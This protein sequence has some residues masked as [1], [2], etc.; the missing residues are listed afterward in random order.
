MRLAVSL[1]NFGVGLDARAVGDLAAAAEQAGWDGL[2]L[3]D[4][5]FASR[6]G[7]STRWTRG[8]P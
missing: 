1:P 7:R 2:F 5:L 6:P 4:H 8:W 3:W